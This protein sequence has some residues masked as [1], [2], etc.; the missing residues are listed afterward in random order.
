MMHQAFAFAIMG[1]RPLAGHIAM[2]TAVPARP[3][4]VIMTFGPL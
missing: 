4:I 2:I 3:A 1:I